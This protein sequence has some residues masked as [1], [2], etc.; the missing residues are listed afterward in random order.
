VI[1]R[2]KKYSKQLFLFKIFL[3]ITITVLLIINNVSNTL[4]EE[5][6]AVFKALGYT[7]PS[8]PL[9]FEEEIS[10]IKE[11]QFDVLKRAP[12]GEGIPENQSREPADLMKAKQ[13][14]CY[15]RSRTFDKV[16]Q[17]LGFETRHVYLLYKQNK[18]FYSAIFHYGQQS[19]AVTEVKTTKGWMM[20]DSNT[21]WVAVTKLGDPI[22]ADDVWRRFAEFD[23]APTY[24]NQPWW[25]LRGVYSRKGQFY[26][27]F[28][29]FPEVNLND[30]FS[31]LI[32]RQ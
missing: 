4:T 28:L 11:V 13:G 15:D 19:H 22:N 7:K 2:I 6:K 24:L 25:A 3:L 27:G 14:L 16:F 9:S 20:I 17:Y 23:H 30:F 1:P 10:L 18:P 32:L 21:P 12:L 8:K 31:W 5:D 29:F 26:G